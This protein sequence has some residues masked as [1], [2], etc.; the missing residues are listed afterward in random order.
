MMT[1]LYDTQAPACE[2]SVR[3]LVLA[4]E[5]G[6]PYWLAAQVGLAECC[7]T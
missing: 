6:S 1:D 4:G 7:S 2:P 3:Q 5:V